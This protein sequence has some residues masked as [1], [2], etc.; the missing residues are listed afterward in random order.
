MI[1]WQ[2]EEIVIPERSIFTREGDQFGMPGRW[3]ILLQERL[4]YVSLGSSRRLPGREARLLPYRSTFVNCMNI[5]D[6]LWYKSDLWSNSKWIKTLTSLHIFICM[7]KFFSWFDDRFKF[8]SQR[9]IPLRKR[10]SS[11]V[12]RFSLLQ[13][14]YPSCLLTQVSISSSHWIE[15]WPFCCATSKGSSVE[16][17]PLNTVSLILALTLPVNGRDSSVAVNSGLDDVFITL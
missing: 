1:H 7:G 10:C 16:T 13:F 15:C 3:V 11:R 5:N 9:H 2:W 14:M 4:K 17:S 8:L 12:N 6:I